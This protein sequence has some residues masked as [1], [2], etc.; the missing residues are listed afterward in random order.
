MR[1]ETQH[2]K[3]IHYIERYGS[4]TPMDAFNDLGITRLAARIHDI[5]MSGIAIQGDFEASTN[6]FGETVH[7]M[8][9][10]RVG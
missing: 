9:Y 4:I 2:E 7:Y 8:R 3:I 10:R 1:K 6:R 5:R